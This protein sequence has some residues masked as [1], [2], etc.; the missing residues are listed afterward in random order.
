MYQSELYNLPN[1]WRTNATACN[2]QKKNEKPNQQK[3]QVLDRRIKFLFVKKKRVKE[4]AR[5]TP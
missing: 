4:Q 2:W 1:D 5:G 3:N